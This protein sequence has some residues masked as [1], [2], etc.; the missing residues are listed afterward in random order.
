MSGTTL[1]SCL[2]R[3]TYWGPQNE[4]TLGKAWDIERYYELIRLDMASKFKSQVLGE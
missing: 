4:M 3:R 2:E 1:R